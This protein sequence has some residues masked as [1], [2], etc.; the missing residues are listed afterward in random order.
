MI[1]RHE[2]VTQETRMMTYRFARVRRVTD[3]EPPG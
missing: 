2:M 1:T 3:L